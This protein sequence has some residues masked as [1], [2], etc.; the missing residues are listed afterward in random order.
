[1]LSVNNLVVIDFVH[2]R[3][4]IE[5]LTFSIGNNDKFAIIGSEGTGK[6]TLLKIIKGEYPSFVD[7][8]GTINR[9]T[10]IAYLEQNISNENKYTTLEDYFTE[11]LKDNE[12]EIIIELGKQGIDFNKSRKRDLSSFS[13]GEKVKI[14]LVRCLI[15]KPDLLLLD[16][17]SNDLDFTTLQFLEDFMND[18]S[19]PILFVSHDQRLLENVANGIIHLQST[20]KKTMAKNIVRRVSYEDYKKY[21][22]NKYESDLMIANKQRSDYQKKI[23]KFRQIFQK[24][25][26]RQNQAVRDPTQGRLL[27]KRMHVLKSQEK[28][29]IKEKENFVDIPEKEEPMNVFFDQKPMSNKSKSLLKIDIED[30]KLKNGLKLGPIRIDISYGD[31]V[32]IYGDNGIGKTTLMKYIYEILLKK[33]TDVGYISQDYQD[34]LDYSISATKFLLNN[35]KKYPEYRIKQILGTLGF[36]RSEMDKPMKEISEGTKLK[37]LLLLLTSKDCEII[38]LDEP[39]RNISPINQDEIYS[40][41]AGFPG[42][43]IAIT[44]DREFIENTFDNVYELNKNGILIP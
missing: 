5:N 11:F 41:F 26:H 32:V 19:V 13:G 1:M 14:G 30:F 20:V 39:T 33:N 16:E 6:S 18:I 37:V 31:K 40:L 23:E 25:E 27:K 28:R 36:T 21:F 38:L 12:T 24:V 3:T 9:P 35:Q 44:H 34:T 2:E 17:P 22:A 7:V 43:I 42:S 29:Y 8:K 15:Q 4:L 10:S